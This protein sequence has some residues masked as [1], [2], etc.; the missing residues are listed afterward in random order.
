MYQL[1]LAILGVQH[2]SN[3][4]QLELLFKLFELEKQQL[5]ELFE[6]LDKQLERQFQ[7]F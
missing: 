2:V 3:G 7:L 1:V 6:S 4:K 5:V